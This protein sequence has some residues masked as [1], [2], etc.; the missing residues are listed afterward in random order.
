MKSKTRGDQTT[1]MCLDPQNV[2]RMECPCL[3]G[4]TSSAPTKPL[5]YQF[6]LEIFSY[7]IKRAQTFLFYKPSNNAR[8]SWWLSLIRGGIQSLVPRLHG[9]ISII[10]CRRAILILL[11]QLHIVACNC[12]STNMVTMILTSGESKHFHILLIG[13]KKEP[14]SKYI[15]WMLSQLANTVSHSPICSIEITQFAQLI[16]NIYLQ[17]PL[18]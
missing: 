3:P 5:R 17:S 1:T 7:P 16:L 9:S 14:R 2:V 15:P 13:A 11:Q 18:T 8:I 12:L 10:F 4:P 6:F